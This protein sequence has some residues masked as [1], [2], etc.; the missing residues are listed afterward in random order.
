LLRFKNTRNR[1]LFTFADITQHKLVLNKNKYHILFAWTL[2]FCFIMGQYMVYA[3]QHN[4][5]KTTHTHT[6]QDDKNSS[7]QSVKEKCELCDSMHHNTMELASQVNYTPA[8]SVDHV[9][10]TFEYDF[11]SIAL[12]LSS[13]R[14]PPVI[15]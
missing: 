2:L 9:Y 11:K 4:I 14:G 15:S 7:K 13:G 10:I 6:T 1:I 5:T 12:I 3:H 8:I